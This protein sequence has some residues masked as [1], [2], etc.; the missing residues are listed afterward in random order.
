M[1][2]WFHSNEFHFLMISPHCHTVPFY[3]G[4]NAIVNELYGSMLKSEFTLMIGFQCIV[5]SFWLASAHSRSSAYVFFYFFWSRDVSK[6]MDTRHIL[7][8]TKQYIY[9]YDVSTQ[10]V[11]YELFGQLRKFVTSKNYDDWNLKFLHKDHT[12][13]DWLAYISFDNWR[14]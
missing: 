1:L 9:R 13:Y 8:L 12:I 2:V 11:Q 6:R 10:Y 7:L 5:S 14:K 4:R 3:L